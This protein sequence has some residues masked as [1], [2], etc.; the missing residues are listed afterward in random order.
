MSATAQHTL[1]PSVKP[2]E[3][4]VPTTFLERGVSIPFT[5]PQLNGARARPGERTELE[6]VIPN[7]S[8]AHGVYIVP[9]GSQNHF[10]TLTVNDRQLMD[11]I[12]KQSGVTP[13]TIRHIAREVAATGLAGRGAMSAA[14]QA[15]QSDNQAQLQ[16]NFDLLIELVRQTEPKAR[17]QY[18]PNAIVPR[19]LKSAESAHSRAL[20][21]D[22]DALPTVLLLQW[23]N[24]L[25]CFRAWAFA[26]IR[27]FSQNSR[28][29]FACGR[30]RRSSQ[31]RHQIRRSPK[32]A[33]LPARPS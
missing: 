32:H 19:R 4:F 20:R 13:E 1:D 18:L 28:V 24:W 27:A 5:T 16:A 2:I 12:S 22:S 21:L 25:R 7:P 23:N 29:S 3:N 30:T 10:C 15:R 26:T 6:L 33:W 8:G 11:A 9:W 14:E 31:K 17:Q